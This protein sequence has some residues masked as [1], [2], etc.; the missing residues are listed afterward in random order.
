MVKFE[1]AT[2]IFSSTDSSLTAYSI[3]YYRVQSVSLIQA[4]SIGQ[5]IWSTLRDD[6]HM[7]TRV[8]VCVSTHAVATT[9]K[10]AAR[11]SMNVEATPEI[12]GR[13]VCKCKHVACGALWCLCVVCVTL[14]QS[15]R[16][17]SRS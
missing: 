13:E 6:V 10:A 7:R 16:A 17:T 11:Q 2:Q 4:R 5:M 8:R 12:T 1:S 14:S 3:R 9:S 15:V